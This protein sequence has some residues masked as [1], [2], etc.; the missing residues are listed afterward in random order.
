MFYKNVVAYCKENGL[1][2]SG[3]E[4][5]CGI[6]NGVIDDWKNGNRNPSVATLQKMEKATGIP[7]ADWMK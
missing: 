5:L 6:G 4:K 7:I 1:S 3:F 2:I